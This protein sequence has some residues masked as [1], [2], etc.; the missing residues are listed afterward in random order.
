MSSNASFGK[1]WFQALN[2]SLIWNE[3]Q[4]TPWW[5]IWSEFT[6]VTNNNLT[7]D[8]HRTEWALI[9]TMNNKAEQW[10][11]KFEIYPAP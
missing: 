10:Y 2:A 11:V 4:V 5:I 3:T 9:F 7:M 8:E 1:V 6:E